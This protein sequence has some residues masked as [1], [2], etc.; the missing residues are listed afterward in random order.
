MSA[1]QSTYKS[2]DTEETLDKLFYRPLGYRA[3]LAAKA[4][5]VSPN[6]VTI[7]SIF[8]GIG[9]G[10]CFY[11]DNP[12]CLALGI[13]LL[14]FS[15]MLDSADG[16]LARMT[17]NY[18]K[19]GRVLDGIATSIMYLSVYAFLCARLIGESYPIWIILVA[20]VSG[21]SH[22]T[23]CN[24]A[25][26]YRNCY[27]EYASPDTKGEIEPSEK[28]KE[29]YNKD[30]SLFERL[31]MR[32][33]Y[34][35]TTTQESITKEFQKLLKYLRDLGTNIPREFYNEYQRLN[36][37]YI[38]Y[39]NILTA[40]TRMFALIFAMLFNYPIAFFAFEIIILNLLLL[41]VTSRQNHIAKRL[42]YLFLK[43]A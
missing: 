4:L 15:E 27:L 14:L 22:S 23:Q 2:K 5:R 18:S 17:Q 10:L 30:D 25:D 38:K 26:F 31:L 19:V 7:F 16:Q 32:F 6:G 11:F 37:P 36:K 35:Y 33:F 41:Y 9:A 34:N 13:F 24:I 1:I 39:Y 40:N 28:I 21:I 20:I 43:G 12:I 3:A 8:T 42:R 29:K